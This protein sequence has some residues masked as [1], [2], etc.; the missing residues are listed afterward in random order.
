MDETRLLLKLIVDGAGISM[1]LT[2]FSNR[3]YLQKRIYLIQL[4]GLDLGYRYNYYRKGPY[5]SNLAND[6]FQLKAD[7]DSHAEVSQTYEEYDLSDFAK[8]KIT[9]AKQVWNVP[10]EVNI[11]TETWLE[12]ISSL[13]YLLH[14]S[15][16]PK[17]C[18][19]DFE[20]VFTHLIKEKPHFTDERDTA[21]VA[22]GQLNCVG[23]ISNKV[24]H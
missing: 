11:D 4:A 17:G 8:E 1:D 7:L 22:W 24:L 6:A 16:W 18:H 15:Y 14:F 9:K 2:Q 12:L 10:S 20:T 13:H 19:P 21:R 23:L 3:F 5:C